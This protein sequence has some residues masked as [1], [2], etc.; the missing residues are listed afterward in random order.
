MLENAQALKDDRKT[1]VSQDVAL[2]AGTIRSNLD[3][4][5]QHSDA[6]CIDVLQRCYLMRPGLHATEASGAS[7]GTDTTATPD[8][9]EWRPAVR[10]L[11]QQISPS[12]SSLSAG[13]RQLLA[14]ARAMLRNAKFFILDE[15]SS[16]I[17]LETDDKVF[18]RSSFSRGLLA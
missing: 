4:F 6:E 8:E 3:P 7:T 14:L 9:G 13:E 15:A 16:S 17:D 18:G 10:S 2:F 12:G 11:R 5:G 1:I